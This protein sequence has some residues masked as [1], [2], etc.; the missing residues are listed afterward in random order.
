MI[1]IPV[2]KG[3]V[4]KRLAEEIPELSDE[5]IA[6]RVGTSRGYV[7]KALKQSHFGREEP[8]TRLR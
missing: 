8:K 2:R 4:A 6:R 1:A 3:L 5:E 7:E